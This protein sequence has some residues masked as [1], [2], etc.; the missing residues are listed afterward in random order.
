MTEFGRLARGP[1]RSLVSQDNAGAGPHCANAENPLAPNWPALSRA[2]RRLRRTGGARGPR[3]KK[4]G[5]SQ[6]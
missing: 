1:P 5:E 3:G 2:L 6:R 4:R